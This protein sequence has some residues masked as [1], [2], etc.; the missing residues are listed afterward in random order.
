MSV[1][2]A[3]RLFTV[4]E[5][6]QMAQA[7]ILSED[8]RVELLEGE[9]VQMTPIGSRHADCVDRLTQR[10]VER[11]A[12]RAIVRVQNPIRLGARSE[13]QPDL[14]LLKP[15]RSYA[16]AHPGPQDVILVVE[17]ADTS[18]ETD[19]AIK[20]PLYA[21][22]GIPE[23]WLVDLPGNG[24]EVY[25]LPTHLGYQEVQRLGHG[26][27]LAPIV[28]PDLVLRVDDILAASRG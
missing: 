6:Y 26:E 28:F 19:R 5:Y 7:G 13:P 20:L 1:Q 21:R 22:A 2:L 17:V 25:R 16:E 14:A 8:D 10:F 3:R 18:A 24:L 15:H 12:R 11:L 9:I 23:A 4:D 27:S